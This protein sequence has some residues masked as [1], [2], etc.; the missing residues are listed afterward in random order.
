M[1]EL[2]FRIPPRSPIYR[3]T[4]V[5]NVFCELSEDHKRIEVFFKYTAEDVAAIKRVP[6]KRYV[7]PDKGGP[8]WSIPADFQAARKLREEF[9]DRLALGDAV[10]AWG[11]EARAAQRNLDVLATADDAELP[12]VKRKNPRLWE[13]L[14]PYQRADAAF[15]AAGAPLNANEPGLGKTVEMIAAII[16]NDWELG[17]NLIVAPATSLETVW[18]AEL[19][20]WMPE[21]FEIFLLS[22]EYKLT[23][24]DQEDLI[25]M[26]LEGQPL[27]LVTTAAQVRKGLPGGIEMGMDMSADNDPRRQEWNYLIV[28]EFH[29]TG[30]T[31]INGDP[32]KGTQFGRAL[33]SIPRKGTGFVSG[34][35]T[36]GRPIRLWGVLN[37]AKPEVF[38]SKWRWAELWLEIDVKTWQTRQGPQTAREITNN[39]L[40]DRIDAFYPE[41]AQYI[42]RRLKR[43]VAP[44]LPEKNRIDVICKMFP[45]QKKQYDAME[46]DAELMIDGE[47]LSADGLLSEYTR[48]KQF[49][50]AQCKL[51]DGRVVPVKS[52]KFEALLERLD[53]R[54]IRP[55]TKNN[56]GVDPEGDQQAIIASQSKEMIWYLD[57]ALR[58]AGIPC[59]MITGDTKQKER[60]EITRAFQA[61]ATDPTAPRVVL[62]TTTAGGTAITLDRADSVHIMDETWDP[63]DQTQVEDRA[64]RISRNHQVDVYYYRSEGS[65]DDLIRVTTEGKE[66][67]GKMVLDTLREKHKQ[68]A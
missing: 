43:D 39:L 16:E 47:R 57:H 12:N 21:G 11:K 4:D 8:Y 67:T 33:R 66:Y 31:N 58:E 63:D 27:A 5:G 34:T 37:H 13:Y 23:K 44:W 25:Q 53:E 62:I 49:A 19:T 32:T 18:E 29:K 48:L 2:H 50:N 22:G 38:T 3:V 26:F 68:A 14:K 42:V 40:P 56:S 24:E 9:G 60:A 52:N 61:G 45:A 51:V 1:P 17:P 10:T 41:H 15:M 64:H 59:Y 28:D 30:A 36:G 35:P 54:G 46:R 7:G 65:I 20:E 55:V 6:G